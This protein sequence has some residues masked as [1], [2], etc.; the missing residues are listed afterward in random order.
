[1]IQA[2]FVK[3]GTFITRV[4]IVTVAVSVGITYVIDSALATFSEALGGYVARSSQNWAKVRTALGDEKTRIRLRGLLTTNPA[5]HYRIS[6]VEER[7][8]KLANAIEEIE[9][10]LGLLEMHGAS[11]AIK[12]KYVTRLRALKEKAIGTPPQGKTPKQ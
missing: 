8:G 9:L 3:H 11:P 6:L 7:D 2:F 5:V 1:M 12:E 10:A 4:A